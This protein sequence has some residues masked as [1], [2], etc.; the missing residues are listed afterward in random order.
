[1]LPTTG[2]PRDRREVARLKNVGTAP[3][4]MRGWRLYVESSYKNCSFPD[5]LVI[6]PQQFYEVRSGR[7]AVAGV[8]DGIDGFV[9]SEDFLWDNYEDEGWLYN[10][11]NTPI[12]RFCYDPGG[13]YYCPLP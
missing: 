9:C 12:D 4:P 6:A 8:V 3:Q 11:I 13:P 1:M 10:D 2:N 7:D 5:G